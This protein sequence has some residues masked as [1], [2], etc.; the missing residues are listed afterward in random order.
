MLRGDLDPE[1]YYEKVQKSKENMYVGKFVRSYCMG[2]GD[3][4]T[5]YWEF[6]I[7][8]DGKDTII[9]VCDEMYGSVSGDELIGFIEVPQQPDK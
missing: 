6:M 1:K 5:I 8:I 4:T 7:V 9:K 2:S 3:G